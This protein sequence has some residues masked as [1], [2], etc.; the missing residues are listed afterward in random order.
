MTKEEE[1]EFRFRLEQEQGQSRKED[2]TSPVLR[3]ESPIESGFLMGLKD[4][5]SGGAQLLPRG[6]EQLTSGFGY[7]PNTV[8]EFFGGEAERVDQMVK[9]E[10]ASY[11]QAR[12]QRGEEGFDTARLA[13]N[14]IN[15]ANLAVAARA[16]QVLKA[17]PT[18]VQAIGTGMATG[19]LQPIT[20]TEDFGTDKAIQTGLAGAG[21]VVGSKLTQVAGRILNPLVTKAEKTMRELGV[22]L[23]PGQM[24]GK[25]SKTIEE[26]AENI[27]LIGSYISNAKERQ[28]FQFNKGVINRTLR[29]LDDE[30]PADVIGRDAIEHVN[31]VVNSQYA[32]V[33]SKISLNYDRGLAVKIGAVIPQSKVASAAGKQELADQL[34]NL[35]YS[36]IPVD[37]NVNAKVS[38]ESFKEIET[39][40]NEQIMLY[41]KS[42]SPTDNNIA[43]SLRDALKVLRTELSSQNPTQ[44][45]KLNKIN[46][47]YG[48]VAVMRTAASN[49]GA[50]NGVFTPKQYQSAVRQRDMSRNKGSF[51]A[52]KAKGQQIGDAGTELL[53]PDVGATQLGRITLGAAGGYGA[54]QNPYAAAALVITTP[55]IYSKAG[56][57]LMETL[58]T[59]RPDIARS[60]GKVLS[61]R[62]PREGSITGAQI[63]EEFQRQSSQ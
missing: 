25:G 4:P 45:V 21:G 46:S 32:S 19:A 57:K 48:D 50:V 60:V 16:A 34:D 52:G 33:L 20:S 23:T 38:G 35:I 51:A 6:L 30:L 13:G 58:A 8:S 9:A 1:F 15:P 26:F 47:V 40:I 43:N 28:L 49:S 5:I 55:A 61:D 22:T 14:V 62:A 44:A 18:A 2:T 3:A 63:M 42:Q 53:T 37:K 39:E 27:P 24:L 56:L 10:E 11:Q 54:L 31:S 36:K 29:K 41:S 7:A 17:A 59:K 12:E